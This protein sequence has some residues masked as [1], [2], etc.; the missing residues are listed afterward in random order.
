MNNSAKILETMKKEIEA[1]GIYT[2]HQGSFFEKTTALLL[3]NIREEEASKKGTKKP[4]KIIEKMMKAADV[5]RPMFKAAHKYSGG[6]GFLDGYR[7]FFAEESFGF[8]EAEPHCSF[9]I[10][11]LLKSADTSDYKTLA[12]DAAEL[13]YYIKAAKPTKRGAKYTPYMIK[14]EAGIIG[15]NPFFLL[16][17]IDYSGTNTIKYT[18]VNAPVMSDNNKALLLPVNCRHITDE[19]F[20]KWREKWFDNNKAEEAAA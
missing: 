4:V 7:I 18:A 20:E 17:L 6:Y 3:E 14:T 5:N 2:G 15:F 13:K 11:Q 8:T 19:D 10:D 12:I 9:N 1:A 16:D